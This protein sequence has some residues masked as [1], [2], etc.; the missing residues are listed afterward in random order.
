MC[1]VAFDGFDECGDEV[2]ASFELDFD[3]CEGV[4]EAVFECDE[5]VVD[6]DDEQED[7]HDDKCD[8]SESD[9][10]S[11]WVFSFEYMIPAPNCIIRRLGLLI[12][13]GVVLIEFALCMRC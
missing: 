11:H 3:L 5:F 12:S 9:P 6:G 13:Y 4:L 2:V 7:S 10:D 8:D 1:H